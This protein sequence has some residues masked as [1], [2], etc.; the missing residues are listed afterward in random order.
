[1]NTVN[2]NESDLLLLAFRYVS[3]EMTDEECALFDEQL[4]HDQ[5]ARSAVARAVQVGQAVALAKVEP[6]P[7][8]TGGTE[9][10]RRRWRTVA[11]AVAVALLAAVA[12][13]QWG[14]FGLSTR[15]NVATD[16]RTGAEREGDRPSQQAN[17]DNGVGQLLALWSASESDFGQ[18]FDE[19][20]LDTATGNDEAA[21]QN[22]DPDGEAEFIV[23]DW[24]LAAV[25]PE[26]DSGSDQTIDLPEE[27]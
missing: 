11:A 19:Q 4:D 1:M 23:P 7:I 16:S 13:S 12:I 25:S 18:R 24:M 5:A 6:S 8:A 22:V 14:G 3:G 2:E 15:D 9:K 17:L 20:T 10:A 27:N 26:D 21:E